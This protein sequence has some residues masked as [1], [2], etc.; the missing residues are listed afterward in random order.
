[1]PKPVCRATEHVGEMRLV[2][3]ADSV[4]DLFAEAGRYVA[5]QCGTATGAPGSPI[6]VSLGAR[7]LAT[8]LVDWINDLIGRGEIAGLAYSD[9]RSLSVVECHAEALVAGR[10]VVRWRSPVKAATYHGARVEQRKNR[11]RAEVLI[12]I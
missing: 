1:M 6:R 11:W 9:F 12:D 2:I 10:R 5:R 3:H 8:L 7:D 4:G